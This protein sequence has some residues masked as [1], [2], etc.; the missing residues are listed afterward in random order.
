MCTGKCSKFIGLSLY[1]FAVICIIC[2]ILLFF[3]GW[4]TEP[5]RNTQDQLTP[6]V[7]YLGGI[8]GGGILVLIPAIHIQAT[9]RQGCCNNRCG[10]FL[11]ILF[12]A[13]GVAGSV[14]SFTVSTVGMV[15]GPVCNY[16][17]PITHDPKW[18][19][20]FFTELEN[21]S[22]ESYLF[23]RETW[24]V[25]TYPPNVA[26]FNIILFS[27]ILAASGIEIIL[28]VTQMLNGL[29]G[30]LCGTCRNKD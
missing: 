4:E 15:R 13:I 9:G 7:I 26:E 24:S 5:V 3:P 20:P 12:A 11:S 16:T 30:C 21:F 2:N 28:C 10:M 25:C 22:N 19:R 29:F 17:D 18:G 23:N 27:I 6:E 8:I 1:P 14:Y